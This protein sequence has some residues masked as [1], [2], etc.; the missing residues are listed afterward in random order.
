MI[1]KL[2]LAVLLVLTAAG[3]A[4][5]QQAPQTLG[6]AVASMQATLPQTLDQGITMDAVKLDNGALEIH[7]AADVPPAQF[8]PVK[9]SLEMMRP[10]MLKMFASDADSRTLLRLAVDEGLGLNIYIACKNDP[11]QRAE[12]KYGVQ[13]LKDALLQ[14]SGRQRQRG[15]ATSVA[16]PLVWF[17]AQRLRRST[18]ALRAGR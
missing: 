18:M 5:A 11:A 17:R 16:S 13:E 3:V 1:K 10:T 7:M 2:L 9:S 4:G 14:P 8:A 6:S 12:L 15:D